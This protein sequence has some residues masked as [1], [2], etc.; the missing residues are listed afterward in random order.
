M[1]IPGLLALAQDFW[2]KCLFYSRMQD[3]MFVPSATEGTT[4]GKR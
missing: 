1:M 2:V 3:D 4:T